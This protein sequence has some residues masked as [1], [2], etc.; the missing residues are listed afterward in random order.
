V[1]GNDSGGN[2]Y[3]VVLLAQEQPL[4]ID[5]ERIIEQLRRDDHV[6]VANSLRAVGFHSALDLL[7]TYGGGAA[8]LAPWLKDA[9][10][11]HDRNLRLQYLAGMGLN[12][13]REASIYSDILSHR[14]Y[15]KS[16][17]IAAEK[18][19]LELRRRLGGGKQVD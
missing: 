1:W 14:K 16:V 4:A 3:D 9:Q 2:G 15:P 12:S 11:N 17:F 19:Q 10:I 6:E 5:V 8:D 13:Y 18:T 7:A